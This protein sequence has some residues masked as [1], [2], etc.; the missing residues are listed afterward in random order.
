MQGVYQEH[1]NSAQPDSSL[2]IHK[3][4]PKNCACM[5]HSF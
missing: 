2:G 1:P 4:Y 3:K 5:A